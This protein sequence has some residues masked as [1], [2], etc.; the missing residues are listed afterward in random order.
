LLEFHKERIKVL[1]QLRQW[2]DDEKI[3]YELR[4]N[5]PTL[6]RAILQLTANNS[7]VV[8]VSEPTSDSV[9]LM[10]FAYLTPDDQR[11]FSR[12]S[13]EKKDCFLSAVRQSLF[14][15]DVDHDFIFNGNFLQ[16]ISITKRIY[17]DGLTKDKFFSAI[18]LLKR[19]IG[20]LNLAYSEHLKFRSSKVIPR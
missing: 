12:L 2:L 4:V 1:R 6:F 16:S 3:L 19:S 13:N 15:L 18:L 9:R 5:N 10:T 14:Y 20:L 8:E 7:I 17:F 11:A